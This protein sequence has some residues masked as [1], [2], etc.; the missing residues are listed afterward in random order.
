M[1]DRT[2]T[3]DW[4]ATP[5]SHALRPPVTT[6]DLDAP[7]S[8]R[9]VH[10]PMHQRSSSTPLMAARLLQMEE[11]SGLLLG[12]PV[13]PS[14]SAKSSSFAPSHPTTSTAAAT[15]AALPSS[16]S[17]SGGT[18][19]VHVQA[20]YVA[21]HLFITCSVPDTVT[22][23]QTR[24]LLL[25]RCDLWQTP[26]AVHRPRLLPCPHSTFATVLGS[27]GKKKG[28]RKADDARQT[29]RDH[30]NGRGGDGGDDD[31]A[32]DEEREQ[33]WRSRFGLFCP[34]KGHWLDNARPL[35]YYEFHDRVELELHHRSDFVRIPDTEPRHEVDLS[36]GFVLRWKPPACGHVQH[37][38]TMEIVVHQCTLHI[39]TEEEVELRHW[40]RILD[41]LDATIKR[42]SR[43]ADVL[44]VYEPMDWIPPQW[45][46]DSPLSHH[47][48]HHPPTSM[49]STHSARSSIYHLDM[50]HPIPMTA[51]PSIEVAS[52]SDYTPSTTSSR[53]PT[54]VNV[55]R[56]NDRIVSPV[57]STFYMVHTRPSASRPNPMETRP[58]TTIVLQHHHHHHQYLAPHADETARSSPIRPR[59]MRF[60]SSQSL[61]GCFLWPQSKLHRR[62][63]SQDM[64]TE[65]RGTSSSRSAGFFHLTRSMHG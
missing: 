46:S 8:G 11:S 57:P 20:R 63:N 28:R 51:R 39:T 61:R 18:R 16:S 29:K 6:R 58:A 47:H 25:L 41:G 15:A 3:P 40:Y 24:D 4:M 21:K 34:A 7:S 14:L 54:P 2:I 5:S 53:S 17:S 42:K 35:S 48:H 31:D 1:A 64:I 22:V 13:A 32:D 59:L 12:Q 50:A 65:R 56:H 49:R 60:S 30:M 43:S 38:P 37:A 52:C 44:N 36:G 10:S 27:Y 23:S 45:H 19:Q 26:K 55:A 33:Q 9:L 62:A